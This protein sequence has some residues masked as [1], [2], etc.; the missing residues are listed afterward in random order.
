MRAAGRGLEDHL[1][2]PATDSTVAQ[3]PKRR[4]EVAHECDGDAELMIHHLGRDVAGRR[5]LRDHRAL[6][7]GA[8]DDVGA[9]L[10]GEKFGALGER[11]STT[12]LECG[13]LR[14]QIDPFVEQSDTTVSGDRRIRS[15]LRC[16]GHSSSI[17]HNNE[18]CKRSIQEYSYVYG[19]VFRGGS[20][21]EPIGMAELTS[22]IRGAAVRRSVM[23]AQQPLEL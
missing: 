17:E 18:E 3:C 11:L 9:G 22:G 14:T 2:V 7:H 15:M 5:V 20:G 4:S 16:D 13:D 8:V 6:R 1:H 21:C 23:A 12:S 19:M 10:V